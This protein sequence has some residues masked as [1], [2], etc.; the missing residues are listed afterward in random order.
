MHLVQ[1]GEQ[2]AVF[3]SIDNPSGWF[4][5]EIIESGDLRFRDLN[6]DGTTSFELIFEKTG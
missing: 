1:M 4:I 6:S 5:Y 2:S 3:T